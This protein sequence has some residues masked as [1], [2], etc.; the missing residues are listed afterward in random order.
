MVLE[1][2]VD[3]VDSARAAERGGAQRVELCSD[4]LEGGVTPSS[5]LIA[6]V[7]E[8]LTILV[9]VLVRPR[10]G[11]FFYTPEEFSVMK[12]DIEAAKAYGADGVVAGV[13]L[14][15][16]QVD[17]ARTTE[18][19]DL[20]RPMELTFHRA[21][22]RVPEI[23]EALDQVIATGADRILTSGASQTAV[24]GIRTIAQ[25]ITRA[26]NR[27]RVMVCGRVRKDN[28]GRIAQKTN[29][30]EFHASLRTKSKSPVTY[31]N[32][33]LSL[34]EAGID[35]FARYAVMADDV[36]ALREAMEE[37]SFVKV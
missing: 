6:E 3:S 33:G 11:D 14:R 13:L 8:S 1:I 31:Q 37:R 17:V 26:E 27:I 29:A 10:A 24:Q 25:I 32:P 36:R 16:G 23:E 7:R 35:E 30:S 34:G 9:F 20:A 15:D 21:I 18:L 19:V 22:D 28:I 2:C 12:R 5:G 4:L